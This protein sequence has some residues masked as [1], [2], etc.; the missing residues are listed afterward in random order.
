MLN[1]GFRTLIVNAVVPE[2]VDA[3]SIVFDMPNNATLPFTYAAGPFLTLHI[4]IAGEPVSRCYSSS[5]SP[6]AAELQPP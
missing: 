5:S 2:T 3:S 1:S 4:V 6:D